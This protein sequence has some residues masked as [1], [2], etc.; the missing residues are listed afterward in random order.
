MLR[1]YFDASGKDTNDGPISCVAGY[2]AHVDEW[3]H[4]EFRWIEALDDYGLERFHQTDVRHQLSNDQW[5]D[6]EKRLTSI[7]ENSS[8]SSV[9]GALVNSHWKQTDWGDIRTIRLNSIYEQCLDLALNSTFSF[10]KDKFPGEIVEVFCDEDDKGPIIEEIYYGVRDKHGFS[11]PVIIG[12]S[13][14][15][16]PLQCADFGA[17]R[18]RRSW[19]DIGYNDSRDPWGATPQGNGSGALSFWSLS[20]G[21]VL[22]RALRIMSDGGGSRS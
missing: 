19:I 17:W 6:L 15:F 21:N 11:Q 12:S 3:A 20:P 2:I 10:A 1:T 8:L 9:G 18:L 14:Q 7:I 16:I 5:C 22:R 4:V 13:S